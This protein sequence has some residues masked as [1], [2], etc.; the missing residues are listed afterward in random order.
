MTQTIDRPADF[1]DP[2]TV[3]PAWCDLDLHD[4][5]GSMDQRHVSRPRVLVLA[6]DMVLDRATVTVRIEQY[7]SR[8]DGGVWKLDPPEVL[9]E[10]DPGHKGSVCLTPDEMTILDAIL[11]E[12]RDMA[13]GFGLAA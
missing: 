3:H 12:H 5:S 2:R 9:L 8:S 10:V 11:A 13:E 4:Y 1:V 7:A 6:E